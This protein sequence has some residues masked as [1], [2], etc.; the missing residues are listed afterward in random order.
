M[1]SRIRSERKW[2]ARCHGQSARGLDG[3]GGDALVLAL[4]C[5]ETGI[6]RADMT[7][8][9]SPA[10]GLRALSLVM[11][12]FLVLMGNGKLAWFADSAH[13]TYELEQWLSFEPVPIS[14][15]YLEWVA[16]PG[17]P[18]FAR[19]VVL[20]EL[21]AGAALGRRFPGGP[22][23]GSGARHGAQLPV[24]QWHHVHVR[25]SHQRVRVARH[26]RAGSP[27][28]RW[29]P[30]PAVQRSLVAPPRAGRVRAIWRLR[31]RSTSTAGGEK[32]TSGRQ[33]I[34]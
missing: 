27:G 25:L 2:R 10:G 3:V 22:D 4:Q 15:W 12:L 1:A 6:P 32:W 18:L 20:G 16:I 26:R 11:G 14:R 29:P 13:L 23:G 7:T 24:R 31:P 33:G 34:S 17:A 9:N 21:A 28:R 19:L 8:L 5:P 30:S